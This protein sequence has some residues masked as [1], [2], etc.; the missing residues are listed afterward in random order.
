MTAPW[1]AEGPPEREYGRLLD[2][3]GQLAQTLGTARDLLTVFRALRDFAIASMPFNGIFVSLYDPRRAVRTAVYAWSEGKEIDLPD[4][5]PLPMTGSPHS[6]AVATGEVVITDD[7]QAAIAGQPR[8]D[9][10]LDVDPRLPRSSLAAPM[11]VMGRIVGGVEV[12][13]W[14]PAAFGQ[15]H[16]TILRIAAN[17]SAIAIDNVRLLERERGARETAE[18]ASRIKDEFLAVVSHELRTPL[19]AI[20]GW[21]RLLRTKTFDL[22]TSARA[23]ETIERNAKL[24]ARLVDDLL[25]IS[26]MI[27]GKLR[28]DV[29]RVELGP[30]VEAAI[31]SVRPS[32][33]AKGI[34]LD[35]VL[36]TGIGAVSADPHRLQQAVWNLL[37][38]AIK[39]T[40]GGGRVEVRVARLE[41]ESQV[42]IRVSD[43][44]RG[45]SPDFLPHVF[46]RFRQADST[47]TRA[48]GGLGLGLA[49]VHHLVELHGGTVQAESRGE[50]QGATFT[51]QLP[52]IAEGAETQ[53]PERLQAAL[54]GAAPFGGLP[55]L[56]GLRV[57]VVDDE[58]DTRELLTLV[59]TQYGVEVRPAA[60]AAEAL[61]KLEGWTPDVLV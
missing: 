25:D 44:G 29:H 17:L 26:R 47:L 34:R 19:T 24:Q 5:P 8:V 52:L 21:V 36:E 58:P 39:F 15:E 37:L 16:A 59:L 11:A 22:A 50:G 3:L 57:L 33:Q 2:R 14:K 38:N 49:I 20:F 60:S 28:L 61:E 46:D 41:P 55:R 27:T 56:E 48:H 4:L 13:S 45:I 40:S 42:Q 12:Q 31:E 1:D 6:R 7:F 53:E 43:T 51:I 10:G 35:S 23:L 18:E 32:A 9:V 54:E 30:I